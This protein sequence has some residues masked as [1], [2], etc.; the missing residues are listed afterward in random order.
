MSFENE[1]FHEFSKL[2]F[3][4]CFMHELVFCSMLAEV[5]VLPAAVFRTNMSKS[6]AHTH[7]HSLTH[8][9]THRLLQ[10]NIFTALQRMST[11][12]HTS[13][14]KQATWQSSFRFHPRAIARLGKARCEASSSLGKHGLEL[15]DPLNRGP[16]GAGLG[17][18]WRSSNSPTERLG[19]AETVT[20][21]L[22]KA[23]A[24]VSREVA[25]LGKARTTLQTGKQKTTLQTPLKGEL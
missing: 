6:S 2:G 11:S 1:Y 8:T 14:Q 18:K 24:A 16:V 4:C 5:C 12:T 13:Q 23:S 19:K 9:Y 7:K 22:R 25:G 20:S 21:R 3:S 17:S 10:T 15:E